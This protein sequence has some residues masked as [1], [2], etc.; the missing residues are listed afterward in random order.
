MDLPADPVATVTHPNPYPYYDDLVRRAPLMR[1]PRLGVWVASSA[2]AVTSVLR[3]EICQV[4]PKA[5]RVPRHL[6]RTLSAHI[7]RN[8]ARMNDGE[9]H[10]QLKAVVS[11]AL[12]TVDPRIVRAQSDRWAGLLRG[13]LQPNRSS[14]ALTD[15]AFR[16]PVYVVAS[17][18]GTPADQLP[19]VASLVRDFVWN[20][21]PGGSLAP[22]DTPAMQLRT[23]FKTILET[24]SSG[25]LLL[26]LIQAAT[27]PGGVN[28]ETII[29]NAIGFLQQT[30]DASAGLIGNTLVALA[31]DAAVRER[32]LNEPELLLQCVHEV[33]RYDAP[34]QN[35]RRFVV[36]TGEVWGQPMREGDDILVILAA[37]NRDPTAIT[38][39]QQFDLDR[40]QR[41]EFS[42]GTGWHA[43]PGNTLAT[44][45][46]WRGVA[47]LVASGVTLERHPRTVSYVPSANARIP[48]FLEPSAQP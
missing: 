1:D 3:S 6:E 36:E 23:L 42:F 48:L 32:V 17:L 31:N 39:P 37:A 38:R 2:D 41:T 24:G 33:L 14:L 29:A 25:P 11:S 7:F 30:Q 9:P 26:A 27:L 44:T 43:C 40:L 34:I 10:R 19:A 18:L 13:P 8:L 45:I 15:F 20:I 12:G 21:G 46:A 47:H 4:R 35:T 5:Q 16:L 28:V 22:D